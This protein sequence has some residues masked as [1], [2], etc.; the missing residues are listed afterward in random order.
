VSGIEGV[1]DAPRAGHGE[2]EPL[3]L[4][5]HAIAAIIG[6]GLAA[7]AQPCSCWSAGC[8]T[9]AQG[10]RGVARPRLVRMEAVAASAG[11]NAS[12]RNSATVTS[13]AVPKW[14]PLYVK[15]GLQASI[16]P[17]RPSLPDDDRNVHG[18]VGYGQRWL[19]YRVG[20]SAAREPR[21][22]V[23]QRP[24]SSCDPSGLMTWR[25]WAVVATA[26]GLRSWNQSR[27]APLAAS[28]ALLL[29]SKGHWSAA[30]ASWVAPAG[31]PP[32]PGWW[33]R[34]SLAVSG[35]SGVGPIPQGGNRAGRP[36][37]QGPPAPAA[38]RVGWSSTSWRI[39]VPFGQRAGWR[40]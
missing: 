36:V 5:A 30:S 38:L 39:A 22:A 13:T 16:L 34:W 4:D 33:M 19:G 28:K 15:A 10:R 7:E 40:V 1:R 25:C 23:P 8:S 24:W 37:A 17:A 6:N 12:S 29:A 26:T 32:A 3:G 27:A 20:C 21:M 14:V 18:V 31:G 35:L 11:R 9:A 2:T